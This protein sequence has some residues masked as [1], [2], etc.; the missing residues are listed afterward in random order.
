MEKMFVLHCRRIAPTLF[1]NRGNNR[2][3]DSRPYT[4]CATEL[5]MQK[6]RCTNEILKF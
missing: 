3:A 1:P 6:F 2:A 4:V 5:P